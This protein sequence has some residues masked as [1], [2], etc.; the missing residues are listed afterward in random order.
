[1]EKI[2]SYSLTDKLFRRGN[3]LPRCP[4]HIYMCYLTEQVKSDPSDAM[5][6]GC[7]FETLA[8]GSSAR[9]QMVIDLPRKKLSKKQEQH[10][11]IAAVEGKPLIEGEKMIDQIRIE[12]QVKRFKQLCLEKS[13]VIVEG[14]NTQVVVY[15]RIPGTNW[16]ARGTLDSFPVPIT[17]QREHIL[18]GVKGNVCLFDLK[19][20][21]DLLKRTY[22]G[23]I[24]GDGRTIDPTQ[25]IFYAWILKDI[26]FALNDKINP[27]NKLRQVISP[28]HQ[29]L[30]KNNNLLLYYWVFEY[31]TATLGN[32]MIEVSY[33][34]LKE[35]ELLETIRKSISDL[36]MME[37]MGYPTE[38]LYEVCKECPIKNCN[39]RDDTERI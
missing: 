23:V 13:M 3:P 22:K 12:E 35:K 6:K 20:T 1:M 11:I 18:T 24:W 19:L 9:N 32:R 28:F 30:I 7:F 8:L 5:L 4:M 15:K 14:M 34:A 2:L 10:N 38:P 39:Q 25:L 27:G 16:I 17:L 29:N 31:K 33:D 21:A 26:D 36:E 37:S